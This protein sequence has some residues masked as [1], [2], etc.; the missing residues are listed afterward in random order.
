MNDRSLLHGFLYM[1]LLL[2]VCLLGY[3]L[4]IQ[5]TVQI[6]LQIYNATFRCMRAIN[7]VRISSYDIAKLKTL[8]I[9]CFFTLGCKLEVYIYDWLCNYPTR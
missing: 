6:M 5:L 7:S 2:G 8:P 4:H 9:R 1:S 3:T